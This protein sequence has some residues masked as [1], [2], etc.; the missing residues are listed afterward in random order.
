V[1]VPACASPTGPPGQPPAQTEGW[2][3]FAGG[4]WSDVDRCTAVIVA[5]GAEQRSVPV[6]IGTPC[7]GQ[8]PAR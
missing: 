6:G 5:A 7:E 2:L 1:R 3:A 4:F 8:A